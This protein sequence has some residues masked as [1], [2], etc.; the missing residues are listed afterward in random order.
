V[1][2]RRGPLNVRGKVRAALGKQRKSDEEGDTAWGVSEPGVHLVKLVCVTA[3]EDM[4]C[5]KVNQ[6]DG[7]PSGGRG[8]TDPE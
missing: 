7:E 3:G 8:K 6:G 2:G 4:V 5:G 1:K